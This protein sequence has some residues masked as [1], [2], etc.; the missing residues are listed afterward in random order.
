MLSRC[1]H[2]ILVTR[3]ILYKSY[4]IILID[5]TDRKTFVVSKKETIE[6]IYTRIVIFLVE[7]E[8]L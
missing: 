8:F 6:T 4:R 5:R 7:I 3:V 1:E 2:G